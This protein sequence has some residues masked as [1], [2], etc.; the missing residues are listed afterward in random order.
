MS[1]AFVREDDTATAEAERPAVAPHRITRA[2]DEALAARRRALDGVEGQ[3]AAHERQRL[4]ALRAAADVVPPLAAVPA[5][6]CFG[7]RVS[8]ADEDDAHL[9]VDIVGEHEADPALGRVSYLSPLGRALVGAGVG[10]VVV[11]RR[12]AGPRRLEVIAIALPEPS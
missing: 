10:D 8:V 11:W 4:D 2:G 6:V 7:A 1:R 12:P 5:R 3:E 9:T